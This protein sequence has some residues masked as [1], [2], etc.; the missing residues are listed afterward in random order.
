MTN[1]RAH[2]PRPPT[3]DYGYVF[4]DSNETALVLLPNMFYPLLKAVFLS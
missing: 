2:K 1:V 3:N 4:H